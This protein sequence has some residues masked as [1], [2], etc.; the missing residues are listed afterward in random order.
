MGPAEFADR[1][2]KSQTPRCFR[3][4]EGCQWLP[5]GVSNAGFENAGGLI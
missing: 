4:F 5:D 2:A 3:K 1:W